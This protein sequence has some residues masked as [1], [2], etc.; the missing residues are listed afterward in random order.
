[1]SSWGLKFQKAGQGRLTWEGNSNSLIIGN[2]HSSLPM[3]GIYC[4]AQLALANGMLT[5]VTQAKA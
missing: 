2:I 1:M 4:T 5:D 3:G